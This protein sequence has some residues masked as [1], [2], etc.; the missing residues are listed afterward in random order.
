[1][2]WFLIIIVSFFYASLIEY[3]AHRW[4]MHRPGLGKGSW[5]SD[6]AIE[7]H[8][9]HRMD[10]NIVLSAL[11]TF[12]A[13]LPLLLFTFILGKWWIIFVLV[14]CML[15]AQIW[16]SLHA[17][18]HDVGSSWISKLPLYK[19]WRQ[20]HLVHHDH[21]NKNFGTIFIWT[22]YLFGT[23]VKKP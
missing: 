17:S 4:T 22:D 19:I 16:S 14:F 5:W 2:N 23:V 12:F 20:H 3:F 10:I 1:V 11:T 8:K 13:A 21:P 18:H 9:K 15:Y 6:H 7:H